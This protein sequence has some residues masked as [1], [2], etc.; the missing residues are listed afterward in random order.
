MVSVYLAASWP[1]A[2]FM[3]AQGG[4]GVATAGAQGSLDWMGIWVRWWLLVCF[5]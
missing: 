4:P 3:G 5:G 2:F 1:R